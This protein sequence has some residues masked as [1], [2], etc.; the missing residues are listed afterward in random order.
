ME[1][2]YHRFEYNLICQSVYELSWHDGSGRVLK[3]CMCWIMKAYQIFHLNLHE[4]TQ[5]E[6]S[7]ND[8]YFRGRREWIEGRRGGRRHSFR[9][10][11]NS[12]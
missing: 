3:R 12:F 8:S 7:L 11:E 9:S 10:E 4:R 5:K 6:M 2:A 1:G